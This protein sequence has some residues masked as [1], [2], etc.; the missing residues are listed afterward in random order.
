MTFSQKVVYGV[1]SLFIKVGDVLVNIHFGIGSAVRSVGAAIQIA[2]KYA[3]FPNFAGRVWDSLVNAFQ[4]VGQWLW[5]V[6]QAIKGFLEVVLD[7]V[8]W[9]LGIVILFMAIGLGAFCVFISFKF[10]MAFRKAMLGDME[11]AIGE[12]SGVVKTVGKVAGR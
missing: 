2:A 7:L 9:L 4:G 1:G 8:T 10:G 3:E 12:V 5:R 11:G 6:A